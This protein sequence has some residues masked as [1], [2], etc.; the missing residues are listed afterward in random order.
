MQGP[1]ESHARAIKQ[2]LRYLTSIT[3][4]GIEYKRGNDMRLVGYSN[5]NVDIDDGHVFYLAEFMAAI[6]AACQAIWLREVL[7]KVM[8]NEQKYM[9]RHKCSGQVFSLEVVGIDMEE[10]GDLLLTKDG[11]VNTY[12]NFIDEPPLIS[13]NALSGDNT[14]R[15]I[16]FRGCAGKNSLHVLVD[17]ESTHN[18][19]DLQTAKKLGYRLRK[20]CPLD[21]FVANGNVMTNL[22]EW[23]IRN[24]QSPFSSP[25]VM[26]K[27]KDGSW[28]MCVD[29]KQLNK[30]TIKDK[31]TILLIE[32]L[33][34]ELNGA[35]VFSKLDLWSGYHQ[36]R[37]HD[38]DVYNTAFRT[39]EGHYEFLV[40][41]FGL[42]NAPSNF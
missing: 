35:N 40:M 4:L 31:F 38:D 29:Y 36:I 13:L 25:I 41:P 19:L 27:G 10:D 22:N 32:E 17:S 21:V 20:I 23:V 28:R 14:Y 18:F 26:V 42:T 30:Y 5:H 6:V 33:I 39:H 34:D 16:R 24:S 8:E 12:Q 37:M 9:P 7:A 15:T 2:I 1:R 11:I 3:S